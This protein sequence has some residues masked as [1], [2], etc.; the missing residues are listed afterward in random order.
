M[1]QAEHEHSYRKKQV[2]LEN[3]LCIPLSAKYFS[4]FGAITKN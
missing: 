4:L 2:V 3:N 1:E